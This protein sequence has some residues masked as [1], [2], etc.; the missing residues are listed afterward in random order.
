MGFPKGG[1]PF[2][3]GVLGEAAPPPFFIPLPVK[4]IE[5]AFGGEGYGV[6]GFV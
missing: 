5:H 2:G 6:Y 4:D 3:S 1:T